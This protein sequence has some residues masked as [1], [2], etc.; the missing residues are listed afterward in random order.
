METREESVV[1]SHSA[2]DSNIAPIPEQ[3]NDTRLRALGADLRDQ[4]ELERNIGR[5]ADQL[6]AEQTLERE[7]KRLE[8]AQNDRDKLEKQIS[9]LNTR[10]NGSQVMGAGVRIRLQA[11]I[12]SYEAQT[13]VFDSDIKE[14]VERMQETQDGISK[15]SQSKESGNKRLATET[16]REFL[17]RTGKITPFARIPNEET[18]R[19]EIDLRD[20]LYNAEMH[21]SEEIT[22]EPYLPEDAPKSHRNLIQPGFEDVEETTEATE[23]DAINDRPTKRRRLVSSEKETRRSTSALS[24]DSVYKLASDSVGSGSE[25]KVKED[26]SDESDFRNTTPPPKRKGRKKQLNV[27]ND[28]D[29]KESFVGLD[30]GDEKIYQARLQGWIS[31][32]RAARHKAQGNSTGT[33]HE[34]HEGEEVAEWH[35]SHPTTADTIFNDG[36]RMPGD[37]YPSL[38]DYQKTG[39]QWLWELY[40]QR[41][42]GIVG[43]EMGLGKTIQV[44]SF[45]AGL[46]YSGKITPGKPIIVVAPATV[47][48][49][50]VNEFHIWW[51]PFRV[52]ILHSSGSGMLDTNRESRWEDDL[53]TQNRS[54]SLGMPKKGH[55]AARK[56]VDRVVREGH[57][58]V[59]TYSGLLSYAQLI[60]PVAWE[61]AVLDEGHKIRN[62]NAAITIA[63][64]ELRTPNRII[65]SGTPIQNNLVELWSLFDFIFP[66][67]LGTLV[68]FKAQFDIPI[69][70]GGYANASNLQ[71]QTATKCA[72]ALKDAI[73]PYLLQRMKADV[74]ADLPKKTERVLFCKLTKVQREA[75]EIF[76]SGD[77]MKSIMNGKRQVL[78]GIDILRKICN[79]PDLRDHRN[80]S[81]KPGYHYGSGNKSGKMVVVKELLD[82]WTKS[83]HKALLFC[84]HR[85]MLDILETY[86]RNIG[87]INYRR[88]DGNTPIAIRQSLVDEFN[89][90]PEAH[91]FLLTTKV[92]GLGVNLTGANR[93]IIYD[94]DWNPS[95]DVQARE[96]AWRLGQ[97]K[98]VEIYRLMVA[99]TIEEKIFHRQI[100][101]QFLTNKILR[102]PKQRQTFQMSDLHDLFTLGDSTDSSTETSRLFQ[103]TEVKF[104]A[105]RNSSQAVTTAMDNVPNQDLQEVV[106]ISSI[107]TYEPEDAYNEEKEKSTSDSRIMEGIFARSGVQS[108]LEHDQ[109]I[110]GRR[111][112]SADPRAIEIEARK[113]ATEAAKELKKA[114]VVARTIPAGI[115]T[116]TGQ[117]GTG[118]RSQAVRAG[119][120][121]SSILL[122]L[123]NRPVGIDSSESS[124]AT[125]PTNKRPATGN[126]RLGK[127]FMRKMRDYL[128]AHGGKVYTQNLI[129]H[130]NRYCTTPERTAEFKAMIKEIALLEKGGRGRGLWILKEEYK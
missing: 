116:W 112:V 73:S 92:G 57:V 17:I 41:V 61:Y 12:S 37:I 23:E 129:D 107:Q 77:D 124:R 71:V 130:F 2:S 120:A 95:T 43:D 31:R 93:V 123:Q 48:K 63:A 4:D 8:R 27:F 104:N 13:A 110:N 35:L 79:H 5:Q 54:R 91:V 78:Y 99:G 25:E 15:Q 1:E 26:L 94:P 80:L 47:M 38:F 109:I 102:D 118:G 3:D 81:I 126:Q 70:I 76:L 96:R 50:W 111:V 29:G 100:F 103:G 22:Q 65:L 11:E 82:I 121:S 86:I 10:L 39:V 85:I 115:P 67:R 52:S 90:N 114:E 75:Y 28:E 72:E 20:A 68:D 74:A 56:I 46:H 89:T 60:I 45:L 16:Q 59:T 34:S 69:R 44:I 101:K 87:G 88:M 66:M 62:P 117:F 55:K 119:P 122:G 108:A 98:E 49:Q 6:L 64:K 127:E 42:G 106:G 36:Y 18:Y 33:N 51:P 24:E 19:T 53:L 14:I 9:Q 83:G 113:I 32:R 125:T 105:D 97:K 58:L 30:D 128:I 40:S 84:Q 21:D 7:Q